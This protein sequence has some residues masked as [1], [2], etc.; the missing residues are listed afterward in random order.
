M[1]IDPHPPISSSQPVKLVNGRFA[2]VVGGRYFPP[3]TRLILENGKIAAMPGSRGEPEQ[4]PAGATGNERVIDLRGKVVVPGLFNT[5]AHLQLINGL[6]DKGEIRQ[7]QIA[8]NL[9]N[10]LERGVTNIRDT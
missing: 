8:K 9:A 6:M 1:T 4:D 2:D 7:R 3:G 10:C 5:H